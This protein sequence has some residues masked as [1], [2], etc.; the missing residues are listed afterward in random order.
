MLAVKRARDEI[1]GV[2]RALQRRSA[3]APRPVGPTR[4]HTAPRAATAQ[5]V[6]RV[7]AF[8]PVTPVDIARC[9]RRARRAP[10]TRGRSPPRPLSSGRRNGRPHHAAP[11]DCAPAA[12]AARTTAGGVRWALVPGAGEPRE[13][14]LPPPRDH[15]T[16]PH[17]HPL[18]PT[19]R[20][21]AQK[22]S[23]RWLRHPR[24]PCTPFAT[25]CPTPPCRCVPGVGARVCGGEGGC[26][27]AC[28][29]ARALG[30]VCGPGIF[31][32]VFALGEGW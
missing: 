13:R 30:P 28:V 6:V 11:G 8:Y 18:I 5:P 10:P 12:D 2:W 22:P 31:A 26:A 25:R 15:P 1:Y 27:W 23:S 29:R 21:T 9:T 3:A 32:H 14:Q 20:C 4:T 7:C 19:R 17:A 16:G 24:M